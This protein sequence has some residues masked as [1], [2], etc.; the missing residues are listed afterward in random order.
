[1]APNSLSKTTSAVRKSSGINSH[2]PI[3]QFFQDTYAAL[4]DRH[5]AVLG[6]GFPVAHNLP[7]VG[8][9]GAEYP[10]VVMGMVG[11][12]RIQDHI[13]A[14]VSDKILI[15][16][17]KEMEGSGSESSRPEVFMDKEVPPFPTLTEKFATQG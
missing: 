1:M 13:P 10:V 7:I 8:D 14:L 3:N 2:L 12:T 9:N 16:G 6:G 15:V 4:E 17:G 11:K 5:A